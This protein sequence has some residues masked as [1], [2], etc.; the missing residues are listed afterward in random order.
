MFTIPVSATVNVNWSNIIDP[1]H[2]MFLGNEDTEGIMEDETFVGIFIFVVL[3]IFT[4][5]AGLGMIIGSVVIIPSLFAI[6]QYVPS[7]Q[8]V[9]GII[10]GL[11][12]GFALHRIVKR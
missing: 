8:I 9:V 2:D 11:I 3:L 7:L 4:L 1:I 5:F 6:F 12:F 10:S